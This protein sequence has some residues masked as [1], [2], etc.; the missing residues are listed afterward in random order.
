M[1]F[2][3]DFVKKAVLLEQAKLEAT[4]FGVPVELVAAAHQGQAQAQ[5]PLSKITKQALD[6]A[7]RADDAKAAATT[8]AAAPSAPQAMARVQETTND[9][10]EEFDGDDGRENHQATPSASSKQGGCSVM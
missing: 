7:E 8:G 4:K 10:S 2:K 1:P 9:D 3:N 5:D 6:K